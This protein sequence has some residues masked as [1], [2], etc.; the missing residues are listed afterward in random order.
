[1][2]TQKITLNELRS[3]VKKIIKEEVNSTETK[4][5][6]FKKLIQNYKK[7]SKE[8]TSL[9]N[10][11]GNNYDNI[12]DDDSKLSELKDKK[13]ELLSV[14]NEITKFPLGFIDKK[15]I[16]NI[17]EYNELLKLQDMYS[18]KHKDDSNYRM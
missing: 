10:Y 12:S 1:M 7:L 4:I 13:N 11:I 16:N 2:K 15:Q 5:N 3:I 17:S 18:F 6:D 14:R 8:I 9:R